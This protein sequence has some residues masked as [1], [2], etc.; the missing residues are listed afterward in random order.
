VAPAV[1]KRHEGS[2]LGG[3]V[4]RTSYAI[5]LVGAALLGINLWGLVWPA[6]L[7]RSYQNVLRLDDY[8]IDYPTAV[9]MLSRAA[10]AEPYL[11]I[12]NQIEVIVNRRMVHSIQGT[13][14]GGPV[15]LTENWVLW[16]LGLVDPTYANY[17]LADPYAA[18][19]RGIGQCYQHALVVVGL[20]QERGIP[21]GVVSLGQHVVARATLRGSP[22]LIDAD[23]GVVMPFDLEHAR[24]HPADVRSAYDRAQ[25]HFAS[26]TLRNEQLAIV[27]EAYRTAPTAQA[28]DGIEGS[29]PKEKLRFEARTYMLK[30][31][32]PIILLLAGGLLSV[33]PRLWK[34][35]DARHSPAWLQKRPAP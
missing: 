13:Q 8:S 11:P 4:M 15:S 10:E 1:G 3:L 6:D 25:E 7:A 30:W 14:G 16:A 18:L 29:V 17:V 19:R 22:Y 28:P 21:S 2:A 26:D 34:K 31:A 27:F 9:S 33:F 23:Y 20:L 24:S 12:E 5:V 35:L 32:V